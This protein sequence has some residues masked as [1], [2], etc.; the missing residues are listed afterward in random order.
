[1]AA[2]QRKAERILWAITV[3]IAL[4]HFQHLVALF[5]TIPTVRPDMQPNKLGGDQFYWDVLKNPKHVVARMV[6]SGLENQWL[7]TLCSYNTATCHDPDLPL[8][9]AHCHCPLCSCHG[10]L[11][12]TP[13]S[14]LVLWWIY[15]F[16]PTSL[17]SEI[18]HCL[19]PWLYLLSH[20]YSFLPFNMSKSHKRPRI[21]TPPGS[22]AEQA[23]D[24]ADSEHPKT[25]DQ[26]FDVENK[27]NEQVLD[28]SI[29]S[30][31]WYLLMVNLLCSDAQM[32]SWRSAMYKHFKSPPEILIVKGVVKY[33]FC[34]K[35]H[36]C[37]LFLLPS[38]VDIMY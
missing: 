32:K 25:F 38:H 22:D 11:C 15:I 19:L 13:H 36:L 16:E 18:F 2:C 9:R 6:R 7:L 17:W 27:W 35:S 30:F 23:K 37:I 12:A 21:S 20:I 10:G 29:V 1:M 24:N 5:L 34:C 3:N 31:N 4:S 8:S 33:K 28:S 26:R 14:Q